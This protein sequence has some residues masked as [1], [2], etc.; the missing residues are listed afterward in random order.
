MS[1]PRCGK[2]SAVSLATPEAM[3]CTACGYH[4]APAPDVVR[5]LLEAAAV[6]ARSPIQSRQLSDS[7]RRALSSANAYRLRFTGISMGCST[8]VIL[9]ALCFGLGQAASNDDTNWMLVA[10][11]VAMV[12]ETFAL[13]ALGGALIARRQRAMEEACAARPPSAP[14]EPSTCHLC[15][16]P[17][18]GHT[19]AFVRCGFCAADNLVAPAVLARARGVLSPW[20]G[21]QVE[22]VESALERVRT[23][24]NGATLFMI[25][26]AVAIPPFV[27]IQFILIVAIGVGIGV[28]IDKSVR[29]TV[30]HTA[31]GECIGRIKPQ[32]NKT[33]VLFG[34][35]RPNDLPTEMTIPA[36][37]VHAFA[38]SKL[39]GKRVRAYT[40]EMGR[41]ERVLGSPLHGNSVGLDV[42]T[43]KMQ[44]H[45][46]TGLCLA[47][48]EKVP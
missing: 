27:L 37:Q 28:D 16:A 32:G 3:R 4:G 29:Y 24:N 17:L 1:C 42:G 40:G 46:P 47:P 45:A 13:A 39:Q 38:L 31:A 10:F 23:V 30:V 8:P 19:E 6:V 20:Y 12:L 5:S 26:G 2:P 14:G 7:V 11:G 15:G 43:G 33:L 25:L 21:S 34:L 22:A 48:G 41:V 18:V 44:L 35:W 9:G 36:S